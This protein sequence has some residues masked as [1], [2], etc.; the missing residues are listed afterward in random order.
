MPKDLAKGIKAK[1]E[2]EMK[3]LRAILKKT[4]R[5]RDEALAQLKQASPAGPT[6]PEKT[7]TDYKVSEAKQIAEG[8]NPEE[9][10]AFV[11]GDERKSI[12]ALL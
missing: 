5:E 4:T 6:V 1:Y 8:L 12:Q 11:A 10:K 2:A 3:N 7:S 9:L